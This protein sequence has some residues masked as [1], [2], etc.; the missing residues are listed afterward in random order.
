MYPEGSKSENMQGI[1]YGH[2]GVNY[3]MTLDNATFLGLSAE[4]ALTLAF[5]DP[6]KYTFQNEL[7]KKNYLLKFLDF[8]LE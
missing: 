3:P 8:Y 1:N 4:D 5:V 7:F 6:G 2:Y